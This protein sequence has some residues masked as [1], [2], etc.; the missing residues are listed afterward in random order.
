[1]HILKK[2]KQGFSSDNIGIQ[3]KGR[4]TNSN[5]GNLPGA[6]KYG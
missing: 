5:Q 2:Q 4:T 1:M 6:I 3:P